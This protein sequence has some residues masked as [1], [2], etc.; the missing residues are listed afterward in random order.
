MPFPWKL[1]E[2]L[3]HAE[4][5]G[6]QDI[7]S[8]TLSG[9]AF[10]VHNREAFETDILP[11]YF[12][13]PNYTSFRRN[14]SLYQFK[15]QGGKGAE[16]GS[17]FHPFF[18][19]E[20]RALCHQVVP[21][22]SHSFCDQKKISST[23]VPSPSDTIHCKTDGFETS[24]ILDSRMK[25]I[26]TSPSPSWKDVQEI[27]IRSWHTI[28]SLE[29]TVHF[30]LL[31]SNRD[32]VQWMIR[33]GISLDAI[34]DMMNV[35]PIRFPIPYQKVDHFTFRRVETGLG[36][37]LDYLASFLKYLRDQPDIVDEIISV[38]QE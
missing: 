17:Y 20:N 33:G 9:K 36:S 22:S 24:S 7:V 18:V 38:F 30:D 12:R 21:R 8:W 25:G 4:Q 6:K 15:R 32:T 26:S 10:V 14:L 34:T 19:K 5:D 37:E 27:D 3:E 1:H 23:S 35:S 29:Q 31:L 16:A 28:M 13:S 2:M 11:L